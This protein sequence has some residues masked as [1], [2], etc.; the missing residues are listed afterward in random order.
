MI[1]YTHLDEG[2][3][4]PQIKKA[5]RNLQS[6]PKVLSLLQPASNQPR[7]RLFSQGTQKHTH[8]S[9]R[10][11][12]ISELECRSCA[13][14]VTWRRETFEQKG[15]RTQKEHL[16]SSRCFEWRMNCRN[17][18]PVFLMRTLFSSE[19]D[20][21]AFHLHKK[22]AFSSPKKRANAESTWLGYQA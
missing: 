17:F 15:L 14:S 8:I 19:V 16:G 5:P 20:G 4:T 13:F 12:L 22:Q 7:C 9:F 2:P 18:F 21:S 10:V 1:L 11:P 3:Q 6:Q